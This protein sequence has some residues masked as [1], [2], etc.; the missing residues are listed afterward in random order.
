LGGPT[1]STYS[2]ARGQDRRTRG[3]TLYVGHTRVLNVH[4]DRRGFWLIGQ[5]EG[6][7]NGQLDCSLFNAAWEKPQP[8]E[9]LVES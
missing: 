8:C 1:L 6:A 5:P 3:A 9:Q 7:C 2:Y 4:C